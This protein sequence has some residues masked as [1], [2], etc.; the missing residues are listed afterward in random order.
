MNTQTQS[1]SKTAKKYI[2][3]ISSGFIT[4]RQII[5]LRSYM[6]RDKEGAR[7]IFAHWQDNEISI[8]HEQAQKGLTFLLNQWKT[9]KGQQRKNNPFGYREQAILENSPTFA[10][11]SLYNA[12]NAYMDNYLPLYVVTAKDGGSFEYYYHNGEVH[13]TG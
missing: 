7:Q 10:L 8:S 4:E 9:P 2:D 6:N 3:I 13:I 12:G 1:I 5:D 11:N